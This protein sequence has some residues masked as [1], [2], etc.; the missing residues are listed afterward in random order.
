VEYVHRDGQKT[1]DDVTLQLEGTDGD[2]L[3]SGES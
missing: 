3:I 2:F 1:S